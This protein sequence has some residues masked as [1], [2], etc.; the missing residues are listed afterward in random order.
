[1]SESKR[2]RIFMTGAAGYIGSRITEFALAEGY[3]VHGLS[4]SPKSDAKLLALGAVPVRGDL[5]S[6][7]VLRRES[8]DADIVINLADPWADHIGD[9]RGYAVVVEIDAAAVN[10]IGDALR[11]TNKPLL[12]TSGTAVVDPDPQGAETTETAPENTHPI[13]DRIACERN[14]L[15]LSK[16]GVNV[17]AIRLAP[18]VYGR[19][20]SGVRLF[21][22]MY[23][24]LGEVVYV[25]DGAKRTSVVHVDDA[26]RLYLLAAGKAGAAWTAG[27]IFNCTSSTEVTIR[28]LAEAMAAAL[29]VPAR[30]LAREEA[31]RKCGELVAAFM[32]MENRASSAKAVKEL[33]WQPREPGVLE[34]IT[35]GP[36]LAVAKELRGG[37]AKH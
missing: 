32:G 29:G 2:Q 11:G 15:A 10:A 4:R 36:Y 21:M 22:S 33:G 27:A 7:D 37:I 12:I 31:A 23:A 1:M 18:F 30:S 16:S 13:N 9:S 20:G 28:E 8:A 3:E 26:A 34:D 17:C 25:G 5:G 6:F 35:S 24:N 19:G 14:A